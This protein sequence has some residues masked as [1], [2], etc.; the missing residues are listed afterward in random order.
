MFSNVFREILM[1]SKNSQPWPYPLW[2]HLFHEFYLNMHYF[3]MRLKFKVF[4]DKPHNHNKLP[5]LKEK[6]LKNS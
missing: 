2:L 1:V 6:K 3:Y 4:E 5:L